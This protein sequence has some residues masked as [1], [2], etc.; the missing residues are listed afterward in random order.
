MLRQIAAAATV[1]ACCLASAQATAQPAAP[2]HLSVVDGVVVLEHQNGSEPGVSGLP[3]VAGDRV[4]TYR[5]RAEILFGNGSALHLDDQTVVVINGDSDAEL[6]AGRVAMYGSPDAAD[7]LQLDAAPGS[8]RVAGV[9]NARV[10][11]RDDPGTQSLVVGVVRGEA[12]AATDQ[13]GVTVTAGQQVELR[14]GE[15]PGAPDW[16][17]T[18]DREGFYEWSAALMQGSQDSASAEYLPAELS[19]ESASF[20]Q[21]GA[22]SYL[23]P[24]GYVWCPRVDAEWQ[25][26]RHGRWTH[27]GNGVGWS[28]VGPERWAW[29]TH[30][31]GRWGVN[32]AGKWYWIPGTAWS[33]AWVRW[34]IAPG[35]VGWSPL[36]WDNRPVPRQSAGARGGDESGRGWTT[37]A[38]DDFR[39]GKPLPTSSSVNR[40]PA[41]TT[42]AYQQ[43]SPM[44]PSAVGRLIVAGPGTTGR[45]A[46]PTGAGSATVGAAVRPGDDRGNASHR[47]DDGREPWSG[48][49]RDHRRP[50]TP[51]PPA[52]GNGGA[53][54]VD[55][56][57]EGDSPAYAPH[58]EDP[59]AYAP[60]YHSP[61]PVRPWPVR[62]AGPV[63]PPPPPSAKP[64]GT[65]ASTPT[66]QPTPPPTP[67]AAPP[68]AHA[69]APHP[70]AVAAP[71]GASPKD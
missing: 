43:A 1:V 31:Y 39:R 6:A 71:K 5:G 8:V 49:E 64:A 24:Y 4:H 17:N 60:R 18:A 51:Y 48:G 55:A 27:A 57:H 34:G 20:D 68:P 46:A 52:T 12:D 30:H 40:A 33:P 10:A 22:W 61:E 45:N 69:A 32:G 7:V 63:Q 65:P 66:P 13:A 54:T 50:S 21:S 14:Q 62:P 2:P 56:Q 70:A 29:A 58:Y 26:Y 15:A 41:G 67:H 16:F 37:M 53:P 44:G 28:F 38:S 3:L 47:A 23:A 42:F 25:P 9:S 36:G 35:Y 11:L 59:R 19:P